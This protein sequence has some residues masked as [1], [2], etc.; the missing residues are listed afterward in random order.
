MVDSSILVIVGATP[1]SASAAEEEEVPVHPPPHEGA[2]AAEATTKGLECEGRGRS[3][4]PVARV[5]SA[6]EKE[7]ERV[8]EDSRAAVSDISEDVLAMAVE[9]ASAVAVASS[10]GVVVVCGSVVPAELAETGVQPSMF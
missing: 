1:T 10:R 5:A 8:Q 3:A 9:V 6:G 4:A 7:S 2:S